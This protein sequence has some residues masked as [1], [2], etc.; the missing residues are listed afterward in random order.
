MKKPIQLCLRCDNGDEKQTRKTNTE[1]HSEKTKSLIMLGRTHYLF[2]MN[3][4][5][6]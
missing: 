6:P 5:K 3:L 4:L 1:V 2:A